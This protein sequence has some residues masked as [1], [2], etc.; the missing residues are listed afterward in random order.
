[1]TMQQ[2][3]CTN[4]SAIDSPGSITS[5]SSSTVS[6]MNLLRF[7]CSGNGSDSDRESAS[8]RQLGASPPS[9][10]IPGAAFL[11]SN[12]PSTLQVNPGRTRPTIRRETADGRRRTGLATRAL[13]LS[14][15]RRV[16]SIEIPCTSRTAPSQRPKRTASNGVIIGPSDFFGRGIRPP[17]MNRPLNRRDFSSLFAQPKLRLFVCVDTLDPIS[18]TGT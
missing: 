15:A 5:T 12:T 13:P 9:A 2:Y 4:E 18:I 14:I 17:R 8:V 3:E 11:S 10:D 6:R 7:F 1:M 16:P